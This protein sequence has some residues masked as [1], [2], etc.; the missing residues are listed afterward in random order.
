ME[1][2]VYIIS[3]ICVACGGPTIEGEMI[4]YR[5]QR[6]AEKDV[7]VIKPSA[8]NKKAAS[9]FRND[10]RRKWYGRKQVGRSNRKAFWQTDCV[11]VDKQENKPKCC[12]ALSMRLWEFIR[13]VI[14]PADTRN[15]HRLR[16]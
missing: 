10:K 15:Y 16:M 2:K 14:P 1:R 7:P 4:C 3:D 11:R 6:E 8:E 9:L 12:V 13:S 5:C